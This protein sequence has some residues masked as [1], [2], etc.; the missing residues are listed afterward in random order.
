[1]SE[2]IR[3]AGVNWRTAEI[4][5]IVLAVLG[6]LFAAFSAIDALTVPFLWIA[7]LL[8]VLGMVFSG[9]AMFLIPRKDAVSYTFFVGWGLIIGTGVLFWV[10]AG[11]I[12]AAGL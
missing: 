8:A 2:P 5:G 1:M 4:I 10:I 11:L 7:I 6:G 12:N 3:P 9:A